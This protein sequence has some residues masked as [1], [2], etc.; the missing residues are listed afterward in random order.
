VRE[1]YQ[2]SSNRYRPQSS[3]HAQLKAQENGIVFPR[4]EERSDSLQL[5]T[6]WRKEQLLLLLP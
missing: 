3:N 4:Y 1:K 2:P 5:A 6:L